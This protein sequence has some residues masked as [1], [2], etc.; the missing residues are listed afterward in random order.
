[1]TKLY[2]IFKMELSTIFFV[3]S[4]FSGIIW[5]NTLVILPRRR[6]ELKTEDVNTEE[7]KT[8]VVKS[9]EDLKNNNNRRDFEK[10]NQD[11]DE[12]FIRGEDADKN[13]LKKDKKFTLNLLK[14]PLVGLL[15]LLFFLGSLRVYTGT[16]LMVSSLHILSFMGYI[17]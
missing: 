8:E 15:S 9:K 3:Y 13:D 10:D 2:F 17:I 4:I 1:M 12:V 5:I 14:S 16:G 11:E 7:V 6:I